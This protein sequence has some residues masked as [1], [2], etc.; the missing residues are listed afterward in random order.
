M[1]FMERGTFTVDADLSLSYGWLIS[2][3]KLLSCYV[4]V[5]AAEFLGGGGGGGGSQKV[6]RYGR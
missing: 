5:T 3:W 1:K 6:H 4:I 2:R